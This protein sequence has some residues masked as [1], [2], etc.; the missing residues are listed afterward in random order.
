MWGRDSRGRDSWGHASSLGPGGIIFPGLDVGFL[1]CYPCYACSV[2]VLYGDSDSVEW[3]ALAGN[4][5]RIC[6]SPVSLCM[7]CIE[8][9][10]QLGHHGRVF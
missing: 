5:A 3:S 10:W 2:L 1:F 9:P 6:L 8:T 7:S 4:V